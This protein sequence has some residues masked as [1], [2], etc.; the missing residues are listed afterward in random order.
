MSDG[1]AGGVG[2]ELVGEEL[3][4]A[5]LSGGL[6]VRQHAAALFGPLENRVALTAEQAIAERGSFHVAL[7]GGGTPKPFYE[8]WSE[9]RH[10]PWDATHVWLVDERQVPHDDEQSNWRMIRTAL[11]D[12]VSI[13][14]QHL[15]PMPV[16]GD[17]LGSRYAAEIAKVFD[18]HAGSEPAT[19]RFDFVLLGMG[20]DAHTASLFPGSSALDER[21]AWVAV[22]DGPGVVPPARVTLT[23]PILN[24]AREIAVLATGESKAATLREIASRRLKGDVDVRSFPICGIDPSSHGGS[25]TWYLDDAATGASRRLE[26]AC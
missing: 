8:R 15:H 7:S 22:N 9:S 3:L 20:G 4:A 1:V 26:D 24:A 6:V 23:F 25:M 16:E 5:G 13:D 19:P 12:R 21:Q 10:F 2:S 14:A 17:D 11:C 18:H